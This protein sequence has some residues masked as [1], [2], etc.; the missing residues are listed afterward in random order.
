[1]IPVEGICLTCKGIIRDDYTTMQITNNKYVYHRVQEVFRMKLSLHIQ[2]R[3][4]FVF[5]SRGGNQEF[6]Q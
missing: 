1:M 5:W 6:L 4:F 2:R 3:P